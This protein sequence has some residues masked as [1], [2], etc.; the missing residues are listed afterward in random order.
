VGRKVPYSKKMMDA[1]RRGGFK[2]GN[3]GNLGYDIIR[4]KGVKKIELY[5]TMTPKIFGEN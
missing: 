1:L 3:R 4:E 5:G 2:Q